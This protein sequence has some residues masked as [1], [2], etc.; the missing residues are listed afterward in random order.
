MHDTKIESHFLNAK[1][2][3]PL[4]WRTNSTVFDCEIKYYMPLQGI[5]F[6]CLYWSYFNYNHNKYSENS[7]LNFPNNLSEITAI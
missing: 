5:L 4:L 3:K 2:D 7:K 6:T 1:S